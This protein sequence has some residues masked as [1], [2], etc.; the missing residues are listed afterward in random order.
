M[1]TYTLIFSNLV[2]LLISFILF[3]NRFHF[4]PLAGVPDNRINALPEDQLP[5]ISVC[6]PARNEE[7]TIQRCAESL[8]GQDYPRYRVHVL[9]DRSEDRTGAILGSLKQKYPERF[10]VHQGEPKPDGWLGKQWACHQLSL[11]ARGSILLFADADT[12]FEPDVLRKTA[13]AFVNYKIDMLTIW[14]RQH[15]KSFWEN[16]SIPLVYY[17]LLGFLPTHY[18]FQK[19]LWMPVFLYRKFA[20]VFAAACGQFIAIR[21]PAYHLAGGHAAVRDQVVEDVELARLARKHHLRVLMM[22]GMETVNCRMYSSEQDMRLGFRK[23]FLAGFG[24]NLPLF[25]ASAFLHLAVFVLPFFFLFITPYTND[26]LFASSAIAMVLLHRLLLAAWFGWN[27]AYAFTHPVG[28]LWFQ[29]LGITVLADYLMKRKI[30][31]KNRQI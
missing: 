8:L 17:A 5:E 31:W 16:V 9:D 27:P 3:R 12:W 30:T 22:H 2:L 24:Y 13:A 21:T 29:Y 14:P 26:I 19:P 18:M 6:I 20:P 28:V 10:E 23:N 11:H 15:L 25:I 4:K 1:I 7:A